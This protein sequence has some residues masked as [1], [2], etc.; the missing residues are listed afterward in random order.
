LNFSIAFFAAP[1]I[2]GIYHAPVLTSALR[3]L[4]FIFLISGIETMSFSLAIRDQKARIS[5]YV[6]MVS[7][8][9]MT[10][11]VIVLASV[12]K[13]HLAL[14]YGALLQRAIVACGSFLFYRNIGVGFA[15]DREAVLDQFRFARL[16]LPSSVLFI[17]LSQYDKLVLLKLFDLTLLGVYGIASNMVAP[18]SGVVV[19]NAQA[20][21]YA[22]CAEYFRSDRTTACTKYYQ[23]NRRLLLIGVTL[24]AMLAGFS[25]LIVSILY[26]SRY[27]LAGHVLMV[28][29]LGAITGAFQNASENLLLASGRT[30]IFLMVNALRLCSLVPAT[31]LGYLFFGFNGFLW[32]TLVAT[33]P[34]LIYLGF[35]QKKLGLLDLREECRLFFAAF[36]IFMISFGISHLLLKFAPLD[37]LH[38]LLKDASK[39]LYH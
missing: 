9:V 21:L 20:I 32:S 37:F 6:D 29:G 2:A 36:L 18:I 8:A 17:V 1:I 4:S 22:R 28:F 33:I 11:C 24:P 38:Q 5:N 19:H 16:V 39:N 14:V 7:T 12:L 3:T 15:F 35:E 13:N 10:I 27:S 31:L 26:D 30:H 23:E 25:Q 34:I